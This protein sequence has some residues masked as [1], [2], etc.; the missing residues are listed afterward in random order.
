MGTQVIFG[1]G[2]VGRAL[3]RELLD[4]GDA[5]R[6]VTRSGSGIDGTERVAADASDA[7]RVLAVTEGA[8]AI[9]NCINP[10]YH[11]WATDWPPVAD[12][13]LGAAEQHG[14]VLATTSNLYVYGEVSAP[15][16]EATPMAST[17]TKGQVRAQMWTDALAAHTAGRVR[18]FEVRGSD[19][20]GGSSLLA[21][22]AP[23]L[24]KGRMAMIPAPLD[25][26]HTWT[27]VRDVAALLA[28]GARDERAWG[29]AWHVPSAD[30]LT[31]RELSALAAEQLGARLKVRELPWSVTWLGGV[32]VPLLREL[33]ETRHQFTRPFVLDSSAAQETF[34]LT[35]RPVADSVAFDLAEQGLTPVATRTAT[36]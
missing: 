5:V 1:A 6:V 17:G 12:A 30:P 20:V 26:K 13:L 28:I 27:D 15:M 16:T 19:Y 3:A 10:P 29:R 24:S 36:R 8:E 11:R 2:P 33:R 4:R 9:Y 34:G 23:A 31:L 22:I 18:A 32:F 7:D 21:M 14:A 25:V 35:P